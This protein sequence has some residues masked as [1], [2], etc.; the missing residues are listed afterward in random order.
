METNEILSSFGNISE[1]ILRTERRQRTPLEEKEYEFHKMERY[2]LTKELLMGTVT[3]VHTSGDKVVMEV[4]YNEV[5]IVQIPDSLYFEPNFIFGNTYERGTETEKRK[6]REISA[7][8]QLGAHVYFTV[9]S[10]I[11]EENKTEGEDSFPYFILG[12]RREGMEIVRDKFFWHERRV[13]ETKDPIEVE[14]GMLLD[15]HVL[16]VKEYNVLAEVCGVETRI[17]ISDLGSGKVLE[18]AQDEIHPGDTLKVLV[19]NIYKN[20]DHTVHLSVTTNTGKNPNAVLEIKKG[21]TYLGVVERYNR[22]KEIYLLRL[23]NGVRA[24]ISQ[25]RVLGNVRLFRGDKVMMTVLSV[26]TEGVS[27]YGQKI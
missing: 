19:K 9:L 6:R 3:G 7:R 15:A 27:G 5:L 16:D 20:E 12:N 2:A 21:G 14:K 10:A 22:E 18:N 24:V 17:G 1:D 26:Y 13:T 8:H 4:S 23:Y 11:R 25:K